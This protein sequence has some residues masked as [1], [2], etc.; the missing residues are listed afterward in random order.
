V[1]S[2]VCWNCKCTSPLRK[3]HYSFKETPTKT[4]EKK[5][6]PGWGIKFSGFIRNDVFFDSRQVVSARPANQGE[7]LLYPANVNNDING[8]DIN[9]ASSLDMLAITTRLVGTVAGPDAFGAK[10][11]GVIEA[12]FWDYKWQRKCFSFKTCHCQTGLAEDSISTRTVLASLIC[13]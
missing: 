9:A 5:A 11:S 12:E 2:V 8:K 4:A 1:H 6:D 10:T 13:N 3:R 7:L